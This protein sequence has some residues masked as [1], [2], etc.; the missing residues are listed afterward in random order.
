MR[1]SAP[2]TRYDSVAMTLH[3]AIA[4]LILIDF[5][6]ALSFSRFN[7]GD[8]LYLPSAYDLHMSTG[9]CI[10]ALSIARVVWRLTH[11]H[12]P[13]PDMGIALH[14]LGRSSHFLLYVFMVAAPLTGWFVLSMRRQATSVFGL[15]RWAWPTVPA[16]ATMPSQGRRFWHDMLLPTHIWL[17]SLGMGLVGV[18]VVAALYHHFRRRDDVLRRMLPSALG[19]I[20]LV[21]L[22]M[23]AIRAAPATYEIDPNHTHPAFEVDH[24]G[25]SMWRGLFR[26]TLGT[27]TLDAAAGT[28]TV[29]IIVDVASVDFGN[30]KLNDTAANAT[31]PAIL[32]APQFPTAHYKGTLSGF[33]NGAP[34]MVTGSLTLH[35]ITRPLVL[36]ILKFKCIPNH[37]NFKREVCGADAVGTFNRAEF[38]VTVGRAYGF[39]MDV[40]LRIQVEAIRTEPE[41]AS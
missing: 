4:L 37:P 39:N 27:V 25:M 6:L 29:D 36:N 26:K 17:S 38:G 9:A 3:W 8:K 28:G 21:A 35:G 40:T 41:A 23:T 30:D 22:P 7:P 13:L 11:R 5:A 10:L 24:Q 20:F 15:F 2:A 33:A 19:V 32:E 12:P 14:W 16:V 31:A 18:H 1:L 34:T